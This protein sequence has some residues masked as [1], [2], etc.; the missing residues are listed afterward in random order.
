VSAAGFTIDYQRRHATIFILHPEVRLNTP[1]VGPD[2][3]TLRE[4]ERAAER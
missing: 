1:G 3:I 2:D 4:L